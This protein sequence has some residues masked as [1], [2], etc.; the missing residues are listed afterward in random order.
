MDTVALRAA[1]SVAVVDGFFR[2][3]L[4][5]FVP[6]TVERQPEEARAAIRRCADEVVELRLTVSDAY[7]RRNDAMLDGA[8]ELLAFTDGRAK[9]GTA[10]T[11]RKA[12]KLG[13]PVTEVLVNTHAYR[14]NRGDEV[15]LVLA[16]WPYVSLDEG[17]DRASQTIRDLKSASASPKDVEWLA[18]RVAAFVRAEPELKQARWIV[19]MPRRRPP[20]VPSDLLPLA[21]AIAAKT[22]QGVLEDYLVRTRMPRFGYTMKKRTRFPAEQ[23][24][25]SMSVDG[26]PTSGILLLDNVITT[27]ATMEGAQ[28]AV[29]RDTGHAPVGLAVLY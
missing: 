29:L 21:K 5:V 12:G 9:G 14:Q 11:I 26:A 28:R 22:R 23:H 24:A 18:S 20:G 19:P 27:G 25:L 3:R 1:C 2:P 6:W 17:T 16:I 10:Y 7:L 8:T 4:R 15:A 13:I